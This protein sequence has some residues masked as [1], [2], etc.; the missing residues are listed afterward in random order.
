MRKF[1]RRLYALVNRRR[2][3]RELAGE[4][5]SHREMLT[6]ARQRQFGSTLRLQE[7]AR[8]QWGWTWL[9]HFRQDVVYGARSLRRAPGF[10][11]TALAVLSLGIG[12]N[13]AEIHIFE[14]LLHH[15]NV[16][17]LDSLCQ[18]TRVTHQHGEERA[19]S[20]PEIQFYG[21]QNTV[22]TA[23]MAETIVPAIY[24][25]EDTA[26][27]R[28]LLVS[29]NYFGELGVTPQY[30]RILE[31]EDDRP[32]AP[33]AAV[34]SND[35]WRRRF[36][37]D[38]GI[39]TQTI[40]LNGKPVR[41][42]GI[43][44][45]SFGGIGW[46]VNVWLT[47][48]QYP[49]LTGDASL[50]AD[51]GRRQSAMFGR[52]KPGISLEIAQA[53][54]RALT[55]E[56]RR[57]QPQYL[58][59]SEWLKFQPIE[60][61]NYP[62]A[63]VLLLSTFVLLVLLV[64]FSACANLGNML[65]ARGLARQREIEIR[66]AIGAGRWRLVRQLMTESF[67]LAVA[68]SAGALFVGRTAATVLL[69]VLGAPSDL[70]VATDWRIL[71]VA[72]GLAIGAMLAFGLA[73]A[74]QTVRRGPKATRARRILVA[75]QVASSCVL[76]ILSTFFARAIQESFRVDLPFDSARLA[77]V[78]PAFYLHHLS[79]AESRQAAQEM[80]A[81]L[82][83]LPGV[84]GATIC[85]IP[86]LRRSRLEQSGGQRLYGNEV[87]P[88]YFPMMR[89]PLAEG[90]IFG[91]N[92]QEVAVISESAARRLWPNESPLGKSLDF[93][94][95]PR[96]VIGVVK[97]SGVNLLMNPDS[98]EVYTP[99]DDSSAAYATILVQTN[100]STQTM[101]ARI[102]SAAATPLII[103]TVFTFQSLIDQTLDSIRKMVMIIG[104]LAVVA[105]LLA[106]LGIFGLLAFT[107]AQRTR[108]I[109]VR[110]ASARG[111]ATFCG[112]YWR[113][114]P[115]PSGWE[116]RPEL[117]WQRLRRR[118]SAARSMALSRLS[119]GV[120]GRPALVRGGGVTGID[121]PRAPR[122]PDRS[123]VGPSNTQ[124]NQ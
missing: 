58:E 120:C 57:E 49:Y 25:A 67:L 96:T 46:Q 13:L 7:E 71:L 112:S 18:I 39:V 17:D 109:G 9:D 100:A 52:L 45:S 4:M 86:P 15:L 20:I 64:L 63:V 89:L 65:L 75:V 16:R 121:P 26:E 2:L 80:A 22:L 21:S 40:R 55:D 43:A 101:A 103:P 37:G 23:V 19:F 110:M 108:E 119:C 107:V 27:V 113:N 95:H 60:T 38:P 42:V 48:A 1:F 88:S 90:R 82:R 29:G 53:E 50:L 79:A 12:A 122:A 56:L 123:G 106:L 124:P 81:K 87:D 94:Q 76:L 5:A 47:S 14:A 28:C 116:R 62:P 77:E 104:S 10:A 41:V 83:A 102:R 59:Q 73:P 11:L 68:G 24:L 105:S 85:T 51:Y 33:P 54:F 32:G 31:E 72:G 74:L 115:S 118:C 8:E 114:T 66:L 78:D 61:R 3:E 30:G 91:P 69:R 44:P 111:R 117:P 36:G 35:Y 98:V 70:R 93:A 99:I 84:A 97:D 6:A 92:E 34:L